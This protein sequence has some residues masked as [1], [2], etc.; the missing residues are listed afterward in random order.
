M[1]VDDKILTVS[2]YP[3]QLG[4]SKKQTQRP[5]ATTSLHHCDGELSR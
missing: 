4:T 2:P 3:Y 1:T 5:T